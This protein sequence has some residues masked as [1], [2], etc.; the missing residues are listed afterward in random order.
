MSLRRIIAIL[1]ALII[2]LIILF[3]RYCGGTSDEAPTTDEIPTTNTPPVASPDSYLTGGGEQCLLSGSGGLFT[4]T[5]NYPAG[6]ITANDSDPEG[7]TFI[8]QIAGINITPGR[9]CSGD[10]LCSTDAN[11]VPGSSSL[12]VN[13]DGSFALTYATSVM[14]VFLLIAEFEYIVT[15]NATASPLSSAPVRVEV[16]VAAG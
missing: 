15:E 13:A 16:P 3:L 9:T 11:F 2:L 6:S 12:T 14:P 8:A 10:F 1:I 5:V 4:C 7:D